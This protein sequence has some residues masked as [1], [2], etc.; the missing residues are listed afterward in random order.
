MNGAVGIVPLA[1]V[2]D[3]AT[4]TYGLYKYPDSPNIGWDFEDDG[5]DAAQICWATVRL[6][7]LLWCVLRGSVTRSDWRHDF[8]ALPDPFLHDQLGLIHPGFYAGL[9]D[10]R[11]KLLSLAKPNEPIAVTG[12]SLGAGRAALLGGLLALAGHPP[13]YRVCFGEPRSGLDK[14]AQILVTVPTH[15]L[16]NVGADAATDPLAH[17]LV[18]D[19]PGWLRHPNPIVPQVVTPTANDPWGLFQFH[20]MALYCQGVGNGHTFAF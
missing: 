19:V 7:G 6:G 16:Q 2:Q 8:A 12:H 20:H 17:D 9:P 14:L 10:V 11:D 3:A 1:V 4:L 13:A 5:I 18:C 15:S